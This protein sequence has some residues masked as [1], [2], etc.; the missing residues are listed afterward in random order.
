MVVHLAIAMDGLHAL[1]AQSNRRGKVL[2]LS[3][4]GLHEGALRDARLTSQ[5]GHHMVGKLGA[6]VGHREGSRAATCLG[7]NDLITS[8]HDAV[9][10]GVTLLCGEAD[11][12]LGLREKRNDGGP[13][14]AANNRHLDLVDIVALCLGDKCACPAYVQGGDSKQLPGVVNSVLL[15]DLSCNGHGGVDRIGNDQ[16]AR[17][18]ADLCAACDQGLDDARIDVEE[19][20]ACHTRLA[21][22]TCRD[23]DNLAPVKRLLELIAG[24][25]RALGVRGDVREVSC[26]PWRDRCHIV[27]GQCC[28]PWVDL[29]QE[30]QRLPDATGSAEDAALE[31]ALLL[32]R[33]TA[34]DSAR[35][36][37]D[38]GAAQSRE[39]G[40]GD[41]KWRLL[42]VGM[43]T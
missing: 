14:M 26:N 12:G 8:K 15:E 25:A 3:D 38:C 20:V 22:H 4:R 13:R 36:G 28:H 41:G 17:L 1:L 10:Q 2:G 32:C 18:G 39:H 30:R 34:R 19:V 43:C 31:A 7:L 5:T 40:L 42:L 37:A 23:D 27:A 35:S 29:E 11:C 16:D 33:E 21:G 24:E 9:C 6:G